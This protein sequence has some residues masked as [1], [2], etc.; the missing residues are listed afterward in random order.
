MYYG[1]LNVAQF[2]LAGVFK[3]E[4]L[5]IENLQI[6]N[7]GK[8]VTGKKS[9]KKKTYLVR[10]KSRKKSNIIGFNLVSLSVMW[11][12]DLKLR[13]KSVDND[14]RRQTTEIPILSLQY[15]HFA[16]KDEV[17]VFSLFYFEH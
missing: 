15:Y 9:Q 12:T 7:L 14:E 13:C 4:S 3:V 17:S 16:N 11:V 10:K 8:K 5:Q 1:P 6:S 2:Y